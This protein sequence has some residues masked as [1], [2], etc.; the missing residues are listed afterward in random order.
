[1]KRSII[2]IL[3]LTIVMLSGCE[4]P[5]TTS[6]VSEIMYY[7]S[8]ELEGSDL[9]TLPVGTPYQ[10][11]GYTAKEGDEDV[12]EQVE[13]TGTVDHTKLGYNPITYSAENSEGFPNSVTRHVYMVDPTKSVAEGVYDGLLEAR[14]GGPVTIT[15]VSDGLYYCNDL[16]GGY[17]NVYRGYGS[18]YVARGYILPESDNSV[19]ITNVSSVWGGI[20]GENEQLM[21]DGKLIYNMYFLSDGYNWGGL[22]FELTPQ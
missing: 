20:E 10:E 14:G 13:V 19:V 18:A 22:N 5:T 8:L 9:V 2:V 15:K 12:T 16:F 4:K 21:P 6:N 3:G 11:P 1:M 7:V 17:Y